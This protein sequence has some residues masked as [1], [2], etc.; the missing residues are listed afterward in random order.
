[1]GG[2]KDC[3]AIPIQKFGASLRGVLM[4]QLI[5]W[6]MSHGNVARTDRIDRSL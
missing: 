2:Y 1:M 6:S 3:S 4:R 5:S